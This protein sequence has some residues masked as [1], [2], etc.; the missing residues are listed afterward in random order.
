[1]KIKLFKLIQ[2]ELIKIFKR[3]SIYVLLIICIILVCIYNYINPNQNPEIIDI[4]TKNINIQSLENYSENL[5]G[6]IEAYI[7]NKESIEFFK[8]Y[9][10]YEV[11]SWQKFA[12]NEERSFYTIG[13]EQIN[14]NCDLSR[15]LKI[16]CDYELNDNTEIKKEIYEKAKGKINKII[17]ILDSSNWK[18]YVEMRIENLEEIKNFLPSRSSELPNINLEIEICKM[19]LKNNIIFADNI[20]NNYIEEY[21]EENY[22]LDYYKDI[23]FKDAAYNH[24]F[25]KC[26][27]KVALSKYAIENNIN[28][29]ISTDKFPLLLDNKI[30][31]RNSLLRTFNNFDIIL[32]V[33]ALYISC[34]TIVDETNRGTLKNLLT[35]PH[36]RATIIIS[37][38]IACIITI[39]FFMIF[40]V[41]TQ[42]IVGGIIFGFDSYQLDFIG[43]D[44][45]NENIITMNLF[46]YTILMGLAKLP[47]YVI[48]SIF[49]I[50]MS[51][52]NNNISMTIILT[53]IIFFI[54]NTIIAEWSKV[55][56]VS[57][58]TRFFIT[59]N[60]DFSNYLFG[61]FSDIDGINFLF[62]LFIY[63]IYF[64]VIL[65][66]LIKLFNKKEI[67]NV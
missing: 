8:I 64:A 52:I 11:D 2:N 34:T 14:Y 32:V 27:A 45:N 41:I 25:Q 51:T 33:I 40:I 65:W 56:Q 7:S 29:D 37:K 59:N 44:Y 35:K 4:G 38:M 12:L 13:K 57:L 47:M 48:I 22:M 66:I 67:K 30:D 3:K 58:I 54:G 49:S 61:E 16:V 39:L 18:N 9:N 6:N 43:Y 36:K 5:K 20:L 60:W 10:K 1:M 24:S 15:N 42:F 23:D 53:L 50:F 28:Q 62:S 21:R 31:A 17:E 46:A 55:E 26:K 63:S 19:R